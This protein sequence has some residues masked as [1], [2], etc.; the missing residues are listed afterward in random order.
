MVSSRLRNFL[1]R[2]VRERKPARPQPELL[3]AMDGIQVLGAN[4]MNCT[5]QFVLV[6]YRMEGEESMGNGNQL[7]R[8]YGSTST[9]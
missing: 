9:R 2:Q 6:V 3:G 1:C 4:N 5:Y 8:V 7:H